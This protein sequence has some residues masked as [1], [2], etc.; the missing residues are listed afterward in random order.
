MSAESI[1]RSTTRAVVTVETDKVRE[2]CDTASHDDG[3]RRDDRERDEA[4]VEKRKTIP[5]L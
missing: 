2:A 3:D 1:S 5:G 4:I